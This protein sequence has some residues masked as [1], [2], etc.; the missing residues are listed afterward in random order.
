MGKLPMR[1]SSGYIRVLYALRSM[2]E[3]KFVSQQQRSDCNAGVR[4][5]E[6]GPVVVARVQ[7]DEID[8][9]TEK[10]AISQVAEDTGQQQRAS[11]EHAIVGPGSIEEIVKDGDRGGNRQH[12]KE[13][14][15]E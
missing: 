7:H 11:A 6:R 9:V 4:D 14:A 13:P 10:N 1:K 3:Y 15:A 12:D 5:V 2:A 8:D